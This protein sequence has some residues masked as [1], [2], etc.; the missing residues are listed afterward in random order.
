MKQG[1]ASNRSWQRL[2][3]H[4]VLKSLHSRC[5]FEEGWDNLFPRVA[6]QPFFEL[7]YALFFMLLDQV[8]EAVVP[9]KRRSAA[10]QHLCQ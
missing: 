10:D 9:H 4:R 8:E 2:I 7:A 1:K 3:L 5:F 6:L